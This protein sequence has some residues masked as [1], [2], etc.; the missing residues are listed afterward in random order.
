MSVVVTGYLRQELRPVAGLAVSSIRSSTWHVE[1]TSSAISNT[2]QSSWSCPEV[3][4]KFVPDEP[5]R[6]ESR[7]DTGLLAPRWSVALSVQ[8]VAVDQASPHRCNASVSGVD[9]DLNGE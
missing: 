2:W 8:Q 6:R 7:F 5:V 4:L 1:T 9:F 3:G